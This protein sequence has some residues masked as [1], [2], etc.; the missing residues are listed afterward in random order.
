MQAI[1][2]KYNVM[3]LTFI[4]FFGTSASAQEPIKL[5]GF[6]ALPFTTVGEGRKLSGLGYD[7]VAGLFDTA[8]IPYQGEGMPLARMLETL[9]QNNAVG[10]FLA[11]NPAREE[12][13]TWIAG[14]VEE[15]GFFF[16][17]RADRK[18][19]TSYEEAKTLKAIG[20]VQSGAPAALLQAAG[21]TSVDLGT[22]EGI[23]AKKLMAGRI[24][25]WYTGGSIAR[26]VLKQ[27]QIAGNTVVIGPR[28]VPAPYWIVGSKT[29]PKETVEKLQAAF[30][31]SKNNG[32]FA[33]FRAQID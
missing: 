26:Y 16:I 18:P 11:R 12:K 14:L 33:A 20:A 10:V 27:E 3:Y 9:E 2:G 30:A 22:S 8:K 23:N 19:V 1:F 15:E 6:E 29:L 24:D 13:F 17:S 25:A 7:F 32:K 31:E 21:I 4:C 5:V 28:I